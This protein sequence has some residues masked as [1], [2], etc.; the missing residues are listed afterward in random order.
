MPH[1]QMLQVQVGAE[2][3]WGTAVAPTAKLMGVDMNGV[4]MDIG[5]MA[6]VEQHISGSLLPGNVA[7]VQQT[8][9]GTLGLPIVG[10]YDDLP[11]WLDSMFGQATPSGGGPYTYAYTGPTTSIT[12]R[13]MTAVYGDGTDAYGLTGAVC[14]ALQLRQEVG[15]PLRTQVTLQG[16]QWLDDAVASLNN[17][18]VYPVQADHWTSLYIDAWAGTMGTTQLTSCIMVGFELNLAAPVVF[19]DGLGSIVPC[20][21]NNM[22]FNG[23]QN[24][25]SLTVRFPGSSNVTRDIIDLL[26]AS[27]PGLVQRQIKLKASNTANR[28]LSIEFCGTMT[29]PPTLFDDRE[30]NT[31]CTLQFEATY[32]PTFADWINIDVINSVSALA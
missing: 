12:R 1:K 30:G 6:A 25:L 9:R 22:P 3:T 31:I 29:A 23:S 27:T 5:Y 26:V 16:K 11:Y 24:T 2:S 32:N 7:Y 15:Q 14:T 21:Y 28:D 13:D 17:R 19:E 10:L 18:T 20:A 4:T 8:G